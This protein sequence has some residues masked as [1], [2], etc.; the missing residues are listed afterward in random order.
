M[1]SISQTQRSSSAIAARALA[2]REDEVSLTLTVAGQTCCIPVL[3]VRDVLSPQ[4]ITPIPLAPA[5]VVGGFNLRGRIVTA[6]DLRRRLGL[7][8]ADNA[9]KAMSVVVEQAGELY[10]LIVDQVDGV[11]PLPS[12]GVC[13]NPSTL[14]PP[15][16]DV[17]LSVYHEEDRLI[18]M[19]DVERLLN[20]G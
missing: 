2:E 1:Q 18:I 20:I 14:D 17:S 19:L 15:W 5:E 6:I 16:R 9:D 10:S 11:L 12:A 7:P 8:P 4:A 3:L 13:P